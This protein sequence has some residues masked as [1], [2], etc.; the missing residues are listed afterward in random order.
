MRQKEKRAF[1]VIAVSI[2]C[3]KS[4]FLCSDGFSHSLYIHRNLREFECEFVNFCSLFFVAKAS[5]IHP[6]S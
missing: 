6:E 4:C 1:K 3:L 5:A 2:Y